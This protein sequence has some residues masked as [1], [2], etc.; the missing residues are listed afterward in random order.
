MRS[1]CSSAPPPWLGPTPDYHDPV[2]SGLQWLLGHLPV[3]PQWY[4]F[5]LF[6][7]WSRA[8]CPT[9]PW[10]RTGRSASGR[11]RRST[12]SSAPTLTGYL[13]PPYAGRPD[14]LTAA[15]PDYPPG[16]KRML[17]DNGV[18]SAA[19]KRDNV[20][21]VTDPIDRITPGGV[22][23]ADGI[24]HPADVHHLRHRLHGRRSS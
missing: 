15:V 9:W 24:E 6:C 2:A 20:E 16:A 12:S 13:E 18:W 1:R 23:T 17:R 19:L 14:L 10:T 21:L 3:Y 7:S 4:R 5:W 8:A 11:C 22:V